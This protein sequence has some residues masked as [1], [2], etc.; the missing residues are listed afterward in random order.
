MENN[1]SS[2]PRQL[3][4]SDHISIDIAQPD[5][6]L[7]S[8]IRTKMEII[9]CSHSICRVK[10][11]LREKHAKA[12][13]PGI[14][15]VGPYH[16]GNPD[17]KAMEDQKWRYM[18]ALLNRKP[19]LEACLNECVIALK[20]VEHRARSCYEDEISVTSNDFLQ[21][22]LVDGC[23]II[24]LF[25]KYSIKS[26]R[27]RNDPVFTTP[28]MLF[29]LR[30]NLILLENQIPL[31]ILQ[32]LF[33]VVPIPK[34]CNFSFAELA[35]RFFKNMIPGDQK[36][37]RERFNQEGNH[38]LDLILHCLLPTYPRVNKKQ[39]TPQKHLLCAKELQSAGVKFKKASVHNLL[40]INFSNG[41]L[42]IPPLQVHQNTENLFRNLIA[43]E[44]CSSDSVQHITSY[45][46]LM[47]SLISTDKDLKLLQQRDI[48]TNYDANDKE[49]AQLFEKICEEVNLNESYYDG[50][51]EQVN[52]YK[53][54]NWHAWSMK[55]KRRYHRDPMLRLVL[56]KSSEKLRGEIVEKGGETGE[57][58]GQRIVGVA[59]DFS[60]CSRKALKWAVDNV[61]FRE[62]DHL[63]LVTVRPEGH[64]EKG[65]MQLWEVTGSPLIPL[66]EFC[67][68]PV[69]KKYGVKTDP[70]TLDIATTFANQK[71]VT[72]VVKI[73]W[74]DPREKLCEAIDN[75][76]LSC[77]IVGNRG[78]GTIK[79][80]IMGS[81]SNYVVSN[82]SCPVTVVKS[83][84][85]GN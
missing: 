20:E 1:N 4:T 24:E 45:A 14:V 38:L 61:N 31:F 79:R 73:Y 7:V 58:A 44:T 69:P 81:V 51:C 15:S 33:Q 18:H 60:P 59:V 37:H 17:L 22:M 65:E 9:S 40:D 71:K 27:R 39:P 11:S 70:E 36:I 56:C 78:L 35:F 8:S 42:E 49:V 6:D 26:L 19:N 43:L 53:R 21:M 85:H 3:R 30:G 54:T 46:V 52:G 47:K 77:L 32:R 25:L 34:Q 75:V 29:N 55:L 10:E 76:P 64:Y 57:M 2:S 72:V 67:D 50:L 74:G 84:D 23:F 63:V 66:C 68:P 62:G 12:Y 82:G 16:H 83:G 5:E 28:G 41:I 13:I 48:L 80:A